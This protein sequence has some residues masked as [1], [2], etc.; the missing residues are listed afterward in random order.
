M[1]SVE[2]KFL[3]EAL[4]EAERAFEEGEVPVGCVIVKE[5]EIVAR[6]YNR[7]ESLKDPTAHAEILA[8]REA[9][10]RLG[11][12]RLEGCS[13]YVTLEPC[14]MCAYA[15]I[16]SRVERV[17]F[18]AIDE[19]HGGVM[20]LYGILDDERLNHKVKWVYEPYEDCVNILKGFFERR[21]W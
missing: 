2:I 1:G 10:K 12:W 3:K 5:G 19:R 4:K 17:I 11:D 20:S 9:G 8:L 14:I 16:L 18:G 13:V 7:R 6:A 21:R 15:L